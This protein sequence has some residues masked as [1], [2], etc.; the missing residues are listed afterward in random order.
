VV[1]HFAF[2]FQKTIIQDFFFFFAFIR[3]VQKSFSDSFSSKSETTSSK[4]GKFDF[5]QNPAPMYIT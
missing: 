1:P 3:K 4:K 2:F 5:R